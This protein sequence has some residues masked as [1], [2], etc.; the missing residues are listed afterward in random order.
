MDTVTLRVDDSEFMAALD[1]YIKESSREL[2][3]VIDGVARD[4]CFAAAKK[5]KK[6]SPA[7]IEKLK[8]E[9]MFHA[10]ATM[11]GYPKGKGNQDK[12]ERIARRRLSA[13]GYSKAIWIKMAGDLG[14]RIRTPKRIDHAK[15]TRSKSELQ[16][17]AYLEITGLEAGHVSDIMQ[18][19]LD[20]AVPGVARK[21]RA[22][23]EKKL[24]DI[25]RKKSGGR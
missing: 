22:H 15:G 5:T 11:T 9:R 19:A 13:I 24:A 7:K 8:S 2:P 16:P 17:T 21:M 1:E 6:A 3:A 4:L 18:P 25:G 10:L 12:A 20:K 14:A 23:V